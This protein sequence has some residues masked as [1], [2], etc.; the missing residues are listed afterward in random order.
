[1][2]MNHKCR[3]LE[4]LGLGFSLAMFKYYLEAKPEYFKGSEKTLREI[5]DL[6]EKLVS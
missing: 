6:I 2:M 4:N 1:M 5:R 3:S